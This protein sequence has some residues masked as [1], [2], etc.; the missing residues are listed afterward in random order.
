MVF[1]AVQLDDQASVPPDEVDDIGFVAEPGESL[2]ELEQ[3]VELPIGADSLVQQL[4]GLAAG[5]GLT[6][7][8]SDYHLW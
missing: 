7:D 2:V 5:V 1:G 4:L 3:R 6:H 8:W